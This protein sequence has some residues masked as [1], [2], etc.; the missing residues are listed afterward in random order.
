MFVTQKMPNNV[1]TLQIL[2]VIIAL[3]GGRQQT[4]S[5]IE[6]CHNT[7]LF[8]ILLET[9]EYYILT[10]LGYLMTFQLKKKIEKQK[11]EENTQILLK[12]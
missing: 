10:R 6:L 2:I 7:S 8:G 11:F 1:V 3:P 5:I 4:I 9:N 12:K